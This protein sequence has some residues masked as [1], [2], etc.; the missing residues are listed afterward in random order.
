MMM[1][2]IPLYALVAAKRSKSG[3]KTLYLDSEE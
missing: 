1:L 3:I 2:T